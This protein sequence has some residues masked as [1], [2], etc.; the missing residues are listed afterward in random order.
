MM[1]GVK[2]ETIKRYEER[3]KGFDEWMENCPADYSGLPESVQMI[4]ARGY[5]DIKDKIKAAKN[6]WL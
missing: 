1:E 5:N 2:S 4:L 6:D 3:L